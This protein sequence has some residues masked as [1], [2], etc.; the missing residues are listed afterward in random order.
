MKERKLSHPVEFRWDLPADGFRWEKTSSL[1]FGARGEKDWY[2]IEQRRP[3]FR[4]KFYKPLE[5]FSGLF[6][7]FAALDPSRESILEFA[8][9]YGFLG[10]PITERVIL[11]AATKAKATADGESITRWKGEITALRRVVELWDALI[12]GDVEKLKTVI[13]WKDGRVQY[14]EGAWMAGPDINP[15]I[16]ARFAPP[17]VTQPAWYALQDATNRCMGERASTPRL[18]WNAG[19]HLRVFVVPQTLIAAIWIQFAFAIGSDYAYKTCKT[20]GRWFQVGP[21]ADMRLD[22]RYCSN[23]CR[24][25]SYRE[26]KSK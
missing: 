22:A 18:L 17:D 5:M 2:L 6:R 10:E 26:E 24:Q 7:T 12:R 19:G 21:G 23:A 8:N 14:V 4:M 25:K 11:P 1:P 20:C 15:D 13:K 9:S 3:P 16:Y